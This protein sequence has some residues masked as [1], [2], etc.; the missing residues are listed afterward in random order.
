MG[1]PYDAVGM[2]RALD[3]AIGLPSR[4]TSASWM[5]VFLMPAEVRRSFIVLSSELY[6]V[7]LELNDSMCPEVSRSVL[8]RRSSPRSSH[9]V[10]VEW[11]TG[12]WEQAAASPDWG[13]RVAGE[14]SRYF[15][16]G[17][18]LLEA[19]RLV[20]VRLEVD[21]DGVPVLLVVY[22]HPF[23]SKRTGLRR[24][25]DRPPFAAHGAETPEGSL[26]AEIAR[27]EISEPLGRYYD[28]LVEDGAG[29]WWWGDGYP[30]LREH[31]DFQ[32]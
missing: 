26:A 23:W 32:G 7:G 9:Y 21:P 2:Q 28:L 17:G 5:L 31:P 16:E 25:L 22:D 29:V 13:N 4:S 6:P 18:H 10:G 1:C 24:R 20:D 14:L 8:Q 30:D 27:F 11:S 3:S 12:E 15:V 19:A